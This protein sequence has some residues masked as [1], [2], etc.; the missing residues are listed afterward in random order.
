MIDAGAAH[1]DGVGLS[2]LWSLP[3]AGLLLSIALLP[4]LTPHFREHH[5]GK[6]AAFWA[7]AF[8]GPC[9]VAAGFPIA[10]QAV[11]HT[12]L[13][14]YVP[15]ILLL[16][17]LFV[18]AGGI[19]VSG[20]LVGTPGTNTAM[21]GA[22]AMASA[23]RHFQAIA[24]LA[25]ARS[26]ARARPGRS[27]KRGLSRAATHCPFHARVAAF[28][29]CGNLL[30]TAPAALPVSAALPVQVLPAVLPVQVSQALAPESAAMSRRSPELHPEISP[31]RN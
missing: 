7:L 4:L 19:K 10:A 1:F 13:L 9:A 3:F 15:F 27:A 6:V 18:V 12:F 26:E 22:A 24:R 11:L 14:D 2:V 16:F 25:L 20:N 8:L 28:A 23:A 30:T 21:L 31:I 29:S 17:T 5:F